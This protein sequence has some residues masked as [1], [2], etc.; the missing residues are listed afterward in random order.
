ME[1]RQ[2]SKKKVPKKQKDFSCIF[3]AK[4][5]SVGLFE[6]T[7]YASYRL[8]TAAGIWLFITQPPN[9]T[10][11]T[12]KAPTISCVRDSLSL[13]TTNPPFMVLAFEIWVCAIYSMLCVHI[14]GFAQKKLT[15]LIIATG[16]MKR[17]LVLLSRKSS[18][19]RPQ[20][21]Q[22]FAGA[23]CPIGVCV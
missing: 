7:G 13:Q 14:F 21:P 12:Q 1:I 8:H 17:I 15:S 22:V 9:R 19:K 16:R 2:A 4:H 23:L 11:D 5:F 18:F 6:S 10:D 20:I 3:P